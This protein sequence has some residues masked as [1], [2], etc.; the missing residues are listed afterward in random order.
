MSAIVAKKKG[1]FCAV[2]DKSCSPKCSARFRVAGGRV[3]GK[4]V[5]VAEIQKSTLT[6]DMKRK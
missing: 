4:P 1:R 2:M 3:C 6:K 5:L